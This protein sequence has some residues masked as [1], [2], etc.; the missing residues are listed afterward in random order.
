[1]L[2]GIFGFDADDCAP[3]SGMTL[4]VPTVT[5]QKIVD[6]AKAECI[7]QYGVEPV[8]IC[9]SHGGTEGGKG[10]DYELAQNTDGIDLIISGHTHPHPR[11][12]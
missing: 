12:H 11:G 6:K 8:V 7:Q 9:L 4:L 2:F 5:A 10:E 1:M 3:N